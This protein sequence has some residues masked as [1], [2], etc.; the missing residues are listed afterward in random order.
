MERAFYKAWSVIGGETTWLE[1]LSTRGDCFVKRSTFNVVRNKLCSQMRFWRAEKVHQ[2]LFLH[3]IAQNRIALFRLAKM[4][5]SIQ[6]GVNGRKEEADGYAF[7]STWNAHI[8]WT[9]RLRLYVHWWETE[10]WYWRVVHSTW[11]DFHHKREHE[12]HWLISPPFGYNN[13]SA[14]SWFEGKLRSGNISLRGFCGRY[15]CFT[16]LKFINPQYSQLHYITEIAS[17]TRNII[18]Q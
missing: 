17:S 9:K 5:F 7:C 14:C 1:A 3:T 12:R 13:L 11:Y 10:F 15:T 6:M 18:S 4:Q 8:G 16:S 2:V